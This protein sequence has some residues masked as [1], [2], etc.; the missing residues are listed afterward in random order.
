MQITL[1]FWQINSKLRLF[2]NKYINK[3]SVYIYKELNNVSKQQL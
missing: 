3:V 2:V 1:I